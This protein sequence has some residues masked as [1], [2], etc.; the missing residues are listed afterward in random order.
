MRIISGKYK[1]RKVYS[2]PYDENCVRSGYSG[3]RP[4]TDRARETLFNI[5]NNIIDFEDTICADLF[6]G[7]GSLG[8]EAISRGGAKC[9]FVETSG[10]QA[11]MIART[12]EELGC[13]DKIKIHT[14]DALKFLLLNQGAL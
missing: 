4:T 7:T 2:L 14:D 10:K 5:L 12:A 13:A 6:A 8:F 3:F 1:S 9:D 11:A